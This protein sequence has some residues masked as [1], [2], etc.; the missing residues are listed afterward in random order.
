MGVCKFVPLLW[1]IRFLP[2]SDR[3]TTAVMQLY[4][5]KRMHLRNLI[6]QSLVYLTNSLTDIQ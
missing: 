2:E 3:T 1:S 4:L 6:F 5:R